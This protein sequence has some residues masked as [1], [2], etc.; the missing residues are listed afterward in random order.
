MT[1]RWRAGK[2]VPPQKER[3]RKVSR[4]F[5][6][7]E[8]KITW[9]PGLL[10]AYALI[11]EGVKKAVSR[12]EKEGGRDLACRRG[13]DA[14]CRAQ[15]DSPVYPH[16]LTGIYWYCMEKLRQPTREVL[17]QKLLRHQS[18]GSCPFL[19]EGVCVVH[20]VRPTG[21]RQFNVFGEPCAEGEDPY[22]TRRGDVLTPDRGVTRR[23]FARVLGFYGVDEAS[24]KKKETVEKIIHTQVVNLTECPWSK[25]AEK[26][27]EA[28]TL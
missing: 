25:L 28:D 8:E 4:R 26:M 27:G 23:A 16:E 12:R 17:R 1:R 10:D 13:C 24:A 19:M 2:Q 6:E 20:P 14:C 3:S 18:G 11:D 7:D 5:P 15:K 9:L 22:H 21:C